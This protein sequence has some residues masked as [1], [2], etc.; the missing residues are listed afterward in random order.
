MR[1]TS[2]RSTG[3]FLQK[4]TG[5]VVGAAAI[6]AALADSA[7]ALSCP[8]TVSV[9]FVWSFN[10]TTGPGLNNTSVFETNNGPTTNVES[11]SSTLAGN[12]TITAAHTP[13]ASYC[14]RL[15]A[16]PTSI[17]FS[18]TGLLTGT[19]A[20]STLNATIGGF[21]I[22]GSSVVNAGVNVAGTALG[23]YTG[24]NLSSPGSGSLNE[25]HSAPFSV[26]DGTVLNYTGDLS[27]ALTFGIGSG[28]LGDLQTVFAQI[29]V[30]GGFIGPTTL[31]IRYTL[32]VPVPATGL[33]LASGLGLVALR[34]RRAGPRPGLPS[35]V[36]GANRSR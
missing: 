24:L 23:P 20:D 26:G 32:P 27:T 21:G 30:T 10:Q 12:F 22:V 36:D 6:A 25:P 28:T 5:A 35:P 2:A 7:Q 16:L 3:K 14:A 9:P 31:N 8:N 11:D 29:L 17:G 33:L 15:D 13:P 1:E 19:F 34:R 18:V 4:V